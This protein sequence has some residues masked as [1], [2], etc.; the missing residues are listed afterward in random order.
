M[1]LKDQ[2]SGFK[3]LIVLSTEVLFLAKSGDGIAAPSSWSLIRTFGKSLKTSLVLVSISVSAI[4][5]HFYFKSR[6]FA[7]RVPE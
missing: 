5:F 7:L 6:L 1:V 2:Q 4:F 3:N